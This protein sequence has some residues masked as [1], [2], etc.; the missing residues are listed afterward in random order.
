MEAMIHLAQ[1]NVS[2]TSMALSVVDTLLIC[3]RQRLER[4]LL[5]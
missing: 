4:L 2:T 5:S 3:H 1:W